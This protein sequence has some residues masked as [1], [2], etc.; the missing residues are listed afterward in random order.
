MSASPALTLSGML[1][2]A[3]P[4]LLI[5]AL[6]TVSL[7]NEPVA[8]F[9]Y[10]LHLIRLGLLN[11]ALSTDKKWKKPVGDSARLQVKSSKTIILVRH[12]ESQW[13]VVFNKGFNGSFPKR[14]GSAL[15]S[16]ANLM[17]TLDSVF[18]DSPLSQLGCEQALELQN[19][20]ESEQDKE[21]GAVLKGTHPSVKS[22]LCSSNLRRALSTGTIGFLQRLKRTQE[23]IRILS[24]LQ[25]IT[26]NIDGVSLA[27]PRSAPQLSDTEIHALGL[28]SKA[29]FNPDRFYEASENAGDKP[30]RGKGITR[31]LS[32]ARWCFERPEP[33]VIACGGHSLYYRFLFQTFLPQSST[34]DAKKY[35][36][37]NG[38]VLA[39][40]LDEGKDPNGKTF[41]G[42]KEDS[43]RVLH[44]H[45][46]TPKPKKAKGE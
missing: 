38:C 27:K 18:V 5:F 37:H 26:F 36:M 45:F 23:K 17:T 32:F 46:E 2:A 20:I 35:K 40:T 33:V 16:E 14:L 8:N 19:F 12:G 11:L 25:E 30:I 1:F 43:I 7:F 41:Y 15:Q 44:G 42:I 39:F 3:I 28:S 6:W 29:D 4:I 24:S 9:V 21:F 13:N 22:V 10:K 31:M 34:H